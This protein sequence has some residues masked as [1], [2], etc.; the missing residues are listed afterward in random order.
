[1]TRSG[2]DEFAQELSE[3]LAAGQAGPLGQLLPLSWIR[4]AL[5]AEGSRTRNRIF[6][7]LVVVWAFVGQVLDADPSLRNALAR[8]QALL[9]ALGRPAVSSNTGALARARCRLPE[10]VLPRL[11]RRVANETS[12]R[13][14]REDLWRGRRVKLVDGTGI[15]MPDTSANQEAYPQTTSQAQGL[16]FPLANLVG[17]FCMATGSLL[18]LAIGAKD[19]SEHVLFR[20]IRGIFEERDIA[21]ADRLYSSYHNITVLRRLGVDVVARKLRARKV[22]FRRGRR[23]GVRDHIAL[24]SKPQSCPAGCS[25][26]DYRRLPAQLEIREVRI[27]MTADGHRPKTI[28]LVTTLLD[29]VA[30]PAEELAKLYLRRW[31]V[32]VDLRHLKTTLGMEVLRGKRPEMVRKEIW[33]HALAHNLIRKLAWIAAEAI[34]A[35]PLRISFKGAVQHTRAFTAFWTSRS[36]QASRDHHARLLEIL[37]ANNVPRRPGRVEPRQRKRRPK[38]YKLMSQPRQILRKHLRRA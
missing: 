4:E 16:G 10:G 32:E 26:E 22:D 11:A 36:P 13:V 15:S 3:K 1:M 18:D 30:Y 9:T 34:G 14:T 7:P 8:I 2:I 31:E 5:E 20:S 37:A 29:P 38:P 17:V 24:W 35:E 25:R 28:T 23:L 12:G 27:T 19:A 21:L 33:A 6:T